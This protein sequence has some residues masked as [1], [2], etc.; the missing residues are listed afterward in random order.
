MIKWNTDGYNK[1]RGSN[2]IKWNAK[3]LNT[4]KCNAEGSNMIKWNAK[5]LNTIKR[6]AEG[7]NM[8]QKIL[9]GSNMTESRRIKYDQ[10][11]H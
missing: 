8:K 3:E 9:M 10:M 1:R 4:I 5:E 7:S 11:E 6:N 2:M